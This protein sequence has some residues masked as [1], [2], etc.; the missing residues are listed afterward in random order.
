[1]HPV[2][3]RA[4]SVI[5]FS[6]VDTGIGIPRDKQ[7]IIFEAF[8]QADGTTS[9]KYGGT[10]LGL[11]ISREL[12]RLLGGEIRLESTP[13]TGSTFTLY[14]PQVYINVVPQRSETPRH[15]PPL[16]P[17][18]RE[19]SD[20]TPVVLQGGYDSLAGTMVEDLIVED[21]RNTIR[22]GDPV[23]LIVEDDVT[24]ARI[25]V[26]MAHDH[27]LK[28]LVALRGITALALAREFRP[29]AITLDISLPDLVGWTILDL[30]K[31]DPLNRHIPV[32][33]ISGDENR[34]RGLMLGAMSYLQKSLAKG[35]LDE[36]FGNIQSSMNKRV[37][38][39]LMVI[40]DEARREEVEEMIGGEDLSIVSVASG[41]E[42]LKKLAAS[43]FRRRGR[44]SAH[45]KQRI[46]PL[47]RRP[48]CA[49][50]PATASHYPVR[51]NPGSTE[52]RS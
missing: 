42:A 17:I 32:H 33:I 21:D 1:M 40:S 12:A 2:L 48:V 39:L 23:L 5:S 20:S 52:I 24:F 50:R 29:L 49:T 3:S 51:R 43:I 22:P 46:Q 6:V 8:Q 14:L 35:A 38:N 7:R 34:R 37:K 13:G 16:H 25:L 9:R 30:L 47:H 45:G 11:S 28:A 19:R 15:F 44:G 31:H 27:G 18:E 4:K 10:G 41:S 26:D 36:A